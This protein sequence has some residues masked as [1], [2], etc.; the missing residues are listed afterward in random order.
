MSDYQNRLSALTLKQRQLLNKRLKGNE[1]EPLKSSDRAEVLVQSHQENTQNPVQSSFSSQNKLLNRQMD[2]SIFFFADDAMSNQSD[3]YNLLIE[4]AKFADTH[5][6]T[7][8]WTPERHFHAFGGLY[9][10]PALLGSALSMVTKHLQIRAGSLV[11]PLHH[12][13]RVAEDWAVVDNLSKGRAAF[14]LASGWHPD[15]FALSPDNYLERKNI[16]FSHL[17][18]VRKLWRGE[19]I[20]IQG[21]GGNKISLKTFPRPVQK[22]LPIWLSSAGNIESFKKAGELGLNI[23]TSLINQTVEE[24]GD[25]I[26]VYRKALR[27]NGFDPE[28]HK[29]SLMIHT[30][31][32]RDLEKVK[33]EVKEPIF[34]YLRTNLDLHVSMAKGR[35]LQ[36]D[37][38]GF[39]RQDE[40]SILAFA[41]ERYF[42]KSSLL[43]TIDKCEMMVNNLKKIGVDECA[44]LLDFGLDVQRVLDSL[45]LVCEL[46]EICSPQSA[47]LS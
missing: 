32:G 29:V 11:L 18:I 7:A 46:K 25:K 34:E 30:F 20:P 33:Q 6:F 10:N 24:L 40:D 12:P 21:G 9:P 43:G 4:S 1:L 16:M 22:E 42:A 31:I 45:E 8:V 38:E 28:A 5:G 44:C 14:A 19:E 13:I 35:S 39:T 23:L 47:L 3:R 17:E 36:V 37:I 27:E 41:F 26:Q 2:F 15:D